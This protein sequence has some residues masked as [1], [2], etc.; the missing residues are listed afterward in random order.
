MSIR[1]RG[2]HA[3]ARLHRVAITK[4]GQN[5]ELKINVVKFIISIHCLFFYLLFFLPTYLPHNAIVRQQGDF[6]QHVL[7]AMCLVFIYF[8]V[9][10]FQNL[11]GLFESNTL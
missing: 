9:I 7:W 3:A 8:V 1:C 10:V 5:Y 4:K 11:I 2:I 6:L